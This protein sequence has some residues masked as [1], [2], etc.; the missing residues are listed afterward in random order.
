MHIGETSL[1][2]TSLLAAGLRRPKFR[3]DLKACRQVVLGE[4]SYVI[5]VPESD[6]YYRFDEFEWETLSL[7]D[8][9]RTFKEAWEELKRR[10][11]D[12]DTTLADVEDFVS[13]VDPQLWEKTLTEKNLALLEKI[14]SER[15]E[16]SE[17]GGSMFYLSFSAWNPDEFF[18]RIHPYLRWFWTPGFFV[19]SLVLFIL[20]GW[21]FVTEWGRLMADTGALYSFEN[22]TL[23]DLVQLWIL[24]LVGGFIHECGHG[25]TCKHYGGEV[26][27][28]GFM[29]IYFMPA[30]FTNVSDIYLFDKDS[31][32]FWTIAA[33]VWVEA[34]ACA[35]GV[36]IWLLSTPGTAVYDWAYKAVLI[37]S[38][39]GLLINF[40][41]LMKFDGYYALCQSLKIDNL[42]EDSFLY[43][44]SLIKRYLF[45]M[46]KVVVPSVGRYRRRVFLVF[47]TLALLYSVVIVTVIL[48][49][50]KN[51]LT[52]K[53]GLWGWVVFGVFAYL[54]LR[55]RLRG[56]GRFV[57]ERI[58]RFHFAQEQLMKWQFSRWMQWAAGGLVVVFILP[59]TTTVSTDF[60]LEPG[61]RAFVR[62]E[63]PGWVKEIRA[64]EGGSVAAGEVVAV[65]HNPEVEARA[66][67]LARQLAGEERALAAAQARGD[68]G[69]FREHWQRSDQLRTELADAQAHRDKLVLR[70]SIAGVLTTP[71]LAERQGAYLA[72]GGTFCEVAN[73][74]T[75]RARVLVPDRDIEEIAVGA[76]VALNVEAHPFRTFRGNVTS[77]SPAAAPDLPP[78]VGALPERRGVP[79]YNYVAVQLEFPNPE[80][81]LRE[82]M[83]GAAK[84]SG[85][86]RPLL[87]RFGRGVW[88][89]ARGQVW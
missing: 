87:F 25:L 34:V 62:A 12:T 4:V 20:A 72:E 5:K 46:K 84:I 60:V 53:F 64:L 36:I 35:I 77:V 29:L 83:T 51:V 89:W 43:L 2:V 79:L 71:R 21:V 22:K 67:V 19:A 8:G 18:N 57:R 66:E 11:P 54:I 10:N 15:K 61:T 45:R 32:R 31:K 42:R 82:G 88:R 33:G 24:I 13:G 3:T 68:A 49:W 69:R 70:S 38:I 50:S 80:A 85:R 28:M 56:L 7:F 81:V 44:K 48:L 30:F 14:R 9:T 17:A 16:R 47:G 58:Q 65:L 37:T 39:S 1:R 26:K 73:R 40:N 78:G 76:P 55:R 41:P 59:L 63:T 74:D 23:A 75:M 86:R 27:Q 6:S 52:T